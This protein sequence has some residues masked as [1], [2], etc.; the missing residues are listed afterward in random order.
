MTYQF[1][2]DESSTGKGPL[3]ISNRCK[4]SEEELY[5]PNGGDSYILWPCVHYQGSNEFTP[6]ESRD[7]KLGDFY[8]F[9]FRY[10][11]KSLCAASYVCAFMYVDL[12]ATGPEG[13]CFFRLS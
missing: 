3:L 9:S 2:A 8:S 10:K 5:D 1:V 12:Y 6:N 11:P 7:L 13:A 4:K